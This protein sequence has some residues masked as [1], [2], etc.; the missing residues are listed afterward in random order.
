MRELRRYISSTSV[1]M[2][3]PSTIFT[4]GMQGGSQKTSWA[5]GLKPPGAVPPRSHWCS[6]LATQQNSSPSWKTGAMTA[7]SFWWVAPIQGSLQ[8]HMSPSAMP[9]FSE[10][11]SS[12]H[13]TAL[14]TAADRYC[15]KGPKKTKLP[16]SSRMHGLKS[17]PYAQIGEPEIFMIVLP[18]S[19]LTFQSACRSTSWVT[20][21]T[22]GVGLVVQAQA[23][24]DAQLVGRDVGVVA[25]VPGD[26][27]AH[28]ASCPIVMTKLP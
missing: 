26:L 16:R 10:R 4:G 14:P 17:C 2:T 3:S 25:A 8:S 19:V 23:I 5:K 12:V 24:G 18:C 27:A 11:F 1:R 22:V 21:S 28:R 9:G 6:V 20:G 13:L 15:R 7:T